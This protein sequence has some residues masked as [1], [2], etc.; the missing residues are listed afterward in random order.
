MD[1]GISKVTLKGLVDKIIFH[2]EENLYTVASILPENKSIPVVITG[3]LE[4]VRPG[5]TLELTGK[6]TKHP[7]YGKQLQVE[8]YKILSPTTENSL[9]KYLASGLIKGIGKKYAERI[10]KH[11]GTDALKVIEEN[12]ERLHEIE[13]FGKKRVKIIV[14]AWNK[15]R[16]ERK[17]L[18]DLMMFLLGKGIGK[19]TVIKIHTEFGEDALKKIKENPYI[20][21]DKISGIGFKKAD[22][23]A[24]QLGFEENSP[25]R[26][27][28]AIKYI[29][30]NAASEGHSYLPESLITTRVLELLQCPQELV[31]AQLN[32]LII[33][34]ELYCE[35]EHIYLPPYYYS[36][37]KSAEKL[38]IMLETPIKPFDQNVLESMISESQR[39]I[40]II[41]SYEQRNAIKK[42]LLSKVSVITGGPGTGK[43]TIIKGISDILFHLN[44]RFQLTAPTGRAAKRLSEATSFPAMTIHRLLEYHPF[45]NA[46]KKNINNPLNVDTLIVDEV[47]MVDIILFYHLLI[48]LPSETQLILVGD[49]DQ[50]P[51]VGPGMV[52]HD[53][54]K[55]ELVPVVRLHEIHRQAKKSLIIKNSHKILDGDFPIIWNSPK[56]DFFFINEDKPL[57]AAQTIADLVRTRLPQKYG[58]DP[59]LD[60]QI[61]TPM[62]KAAIGAD[63]LNLVLQEKLNTHHKTSLQLGKFMVNDKVMQIVNNYDKDVYNGDIGQVKD[64]SIPGKKLVVEFPEGCITY[65]SSELDQLILAYAITIHKSQG[66]EFPAVII[67]LFTQ[68]ALLLRRNLLY[69]AFTRAKKIAVLI[70]TYKA[71]GMS[72]HNN[73]IAER[74]SGLFERLSKKKLDKLSLF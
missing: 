16:E 44:K 15:E 2:S 59:I 34:K 51:S 13:G 10:V 3:I 46:F 7:S 45:E 17:S 47:S 12:P 33:N 71:L 32:T 63:N 64:I 30:N 53:L 35:N 27:A 67:P 20:L 66:S 60:I 23:I 69:T 58:F 26:V 38:G 9:Q 29:L 6:W 25:F 31:E 68:H 72:V 73:E 54:I 56:S 24:S 65:K 43:T 70:G 40:G 18:K 5:E 42:S 11:F 22:I 48:A 62:Y 19:N 52:L 21:A 50:L 41:Y 8:D 4:G 57:H 37:E 28:A 36:E 55:S 74:F 49:C 61:I 39:D 1:N 14:K